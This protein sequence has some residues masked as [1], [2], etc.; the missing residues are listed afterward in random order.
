MKS[1]TVPR[2]E[3]IRLIRKWNFEQTSKD[4][5]QALDLTPSGKTHL[6]SKIV[7]CVICIGTS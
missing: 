5:L 2:L 4:D 1:P 7:I 3:T 6:A